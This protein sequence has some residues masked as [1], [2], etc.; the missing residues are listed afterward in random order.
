M[1]YVDYGVNI[2]LM[3]MAEIDGRK[4]QSDL[5][6]LY[7]RNF[8]PDSDWQY[9]PEEIKI[10]DTSV[11]L[12][13]LFSCWFLDSVL[14]KILRDS[15]RANGENEVIE[16]P[17][18]Q[19]HQKYSNLL[20]EM[21]EKLREANKFFN[22]GSNGTKVG[23]VF[24]DYKIMR[25]LAYLRAGGLNYYLLTQEEFAQLPPKERERIIEAFNKGMTSLDKD[26]NPQMS[27]DEAFKKAQEIVA[28]YWW[29]KTSPNT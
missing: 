8:F 2:N 13:S 25:H 4:N 10:G 15:Y 12:V 26:F 23:S 22:Y 5:R 28:Q 9:P 19:D 24:M 18:F 3:K 6:E 1:H 21:E 20:S 16:M 11:S 27:T 29:P 14:A 17:I 7:Y